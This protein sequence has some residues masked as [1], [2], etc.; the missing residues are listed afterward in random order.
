M[1]LGLGLGLGLGRLGRL[2]RRRRQRQRAATWKLGLPSPAPTSMKTGGRRRRRLLARHHSLQQSARTACGLGAARHVRRPRPSVQAPSA[3]GLHEL[4]RRRRSLPPD[5]GAGSRPRRPAP[6]LQQPH[7]HTH[8]HARTRTHIHHPRTHAPT[9]PRTGTH[10]PTHTRAA[11]YVLRSS[12]DSPSTTPCP[13]SQVMRERG[14]VTFT[15]ADHSLWL[16]GGQICTE[17]GR[18]ESR[19]HWTHWL[20]KR[21][22]WRYL[23]RVSSP[24]TTLDQGSFV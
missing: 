12:A 7:T 17:N 14:S 24:A 6:Q 11:A 2:G 21:V 9:Y 23:V 8:A 20:S 13:I 4:R 18:R 19:T 16:S 22:Q 1:G 15:A 3:Q 10:A 5:G